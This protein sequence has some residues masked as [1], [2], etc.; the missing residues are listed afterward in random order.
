VADPAKQKEEAKPSRWRDHIEAATMAIVVAVMLKYFIIEA[1]QIPSGS[2]QPTLMGSPEAGV[3]DRILVDKLSYHFRDPER[4]EVV[5]F[6]YPLDRSKSFI[7]RCVGLPD[8]DFSIQFGDLWR[9]RDASEPW[10]VLRRPQPVQDT[11]WKRI[12]SVDPAFARWSPDGGARGWTIDGRA[13]ITA[14]GNGS[15]RLPAS[16]PGFVDVY[17]DGYPGELPALIANSERVRKGLVPSGRNQI[18]DLRLEGEVRAEA[19]LKTLAIELREGERLYRFTLPGPACAAQFEPWH[20]EVPPASKPYPDQPDARV[21]RYAP[22]GGEAARDGQPYA[23]RLPAGQALS[24]AVQNMDDLLRLELDGQTV[25]EIEIP[26]AHDQR[27]SLTLRVDGDAQLTDLEVYRDIYYTQPQDNV[28]EF[29][30]PPGCYVMLGDN[31]QD[32]SD[33]REWKFTSF[34]PEVGPLAGRTVRGNLRGN[35]ENPAIVSQPGEPRVFFRD[36]W[37]ERHDFPLRNS[38]RGTP[39]PA[40]FVPRELIAGR[41]VLVFWPMAPALDV[42]RLKFV[43]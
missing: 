9:R 35:N 14:R 12:E 22:P 34:T 41:A 27:S 42:W 39:E 21:V 23:W 24:F 19:N 8:E 32:S 13:A 40:P 29:H 26:A 16:G 6:K 28:S 31:T 30:I 10:Q 25:L 18:G 43:R 3:F 1:Y 5:V 7:K 11:V 37:G 15:V 20:V 2:M 4:W 38:Q 36:E 17:V 33:S